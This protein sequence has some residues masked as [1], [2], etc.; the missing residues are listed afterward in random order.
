MVLGTVRVRVHP[1]VSS[2]SE[3]WKVLDRVKSLVESME[4]RV[5]SPSKTH[6]L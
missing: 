2:D 1:S 3:S 4:L 6:R 5:N